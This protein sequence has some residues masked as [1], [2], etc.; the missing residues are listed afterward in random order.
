[1]DE[2]VKLVSK[3]AGITEDQA[4]IAVQVVANVLKDRMP[5]GL[6]SQV[7]VYLKGNGGK[8]DLG[9]IG[10]KLGGMFGKK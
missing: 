8:N 1:M 7:D 5:E 9:D 4:R 10:G 6:A 2:V 3:K